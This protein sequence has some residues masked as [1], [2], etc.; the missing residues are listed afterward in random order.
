MEGL[1]KANVSRLAVI[2]VYIIFLLLDNRELGEMKPAFRRELEMHVFSLSS[3]SDVRVL[4]MLAQ[5]IL[6]N[7]T[8]LFCF[9][10]SVLPRSNP[11]C[12]VR[13]I[14]YFPVSFS[15]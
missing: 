12:V 1:P 6:Q 15:C 7:K 13:L 11:I 8:P 14:Y 9:I 10:I 2:R 4:L 3:M 5:V